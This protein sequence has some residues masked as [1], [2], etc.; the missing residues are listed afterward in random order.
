MAKHYSG[1]GGARASA[2]HLTH[3]FPGEHYLVIRPVRDDLRRSVVDVPRRSQKV[4]SRQRRKDSR[5]ISRLTRDAHKGKLAKTKQ[6]SSTGRAMPPTAKS[7]PMGSNK[8]IRMGATAAHSGR[9][10]KPVKDTGI[11]IHRPRA[12]RPHPPRG[13]H[14]LPLQRISERL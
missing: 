13:Y 14:L 5:K 10:Q 4:R 12:L 6:N 9:G 2:R 3:K 1:R 7:R 11:R 8:E